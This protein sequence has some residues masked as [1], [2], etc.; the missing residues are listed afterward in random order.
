MRF[1]RLPFL[2]MAVAVVVFI[3]YMGSWNKSQCKPVCNSIPCGDGRVHIVSS[4]PV[5]HQFKIH[6]IDFECFS[7][8]VPRNTT[9]TR[10]STCCLSVIDLWRSMR[11]R[12]I[13]RFNPMFEL[14]RILM[15][16]T[17][18]DFYRLHAF[19]FRFCLAL[20][21]YGRRYSGGGH[22]TR[23]SVVLEST[24]SRLRNSGS[25]TPDNGSEAHR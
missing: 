12:S 1:K 22:C 17:C 6:V 5:F 20:P 18:G 7:E 21:W 23:R 19:S 9:C 3:L 2:W 4:N 14:I 16:G 10:Y 24:Q 8:V 15:G 13:R 25:M 11:P